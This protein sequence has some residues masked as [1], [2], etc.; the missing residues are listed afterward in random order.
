MRAV[1]ITK[2]GAPSRRGRLLSAVSMAALCT[3]LQKPAFA[4]DASDAGT[5]AVT[6]TSTRVQREGYSAPTPVTAVST[7]DLEQQ[8]PSTVGDVL[9][10]LPSFRATSTPTT[11]G[12]NSL[13]GGQVTADLRGLGASRTLV[14]VNGKRFVPAASD[15]TSDLTQIPTLLVDRVEVVT[16]GA[17]AAYG[18]DAVSGVVNFILNNHLEGLKA[19]LQYTESKYSDDIEEQAALAYGATALSGKLHFMF[20]AD[21][22]NNEGIGGQYTRPWGRQEVG[23]I[24][25]SNF[26]INKQPQ[27]IISPNVHT[28]TMSNGGLIV[29]AKTAAG[30]TSTALNGIAFGPGGTPYKFNFGTVYGSSMIG[31]EQAEPNPTLNSNL[32]KPF[33][34]ITGLSRIEYEITP[35]VTAY[36]EVSAAR[37]GAGGASQQARDTGLVIKG[38]NAFLPASIKSAM[39]ANNLSSITLGRYYDDT[40]LI[41]L[42]TTNQTYRV[43][44]GL[45]GDVNLFGDWKWDANYQYGK[46]TYFLNFGP[47]NRNQA[48]FLL[49]SDAV[50]GPGGAI[51]CRST[52][53][54]PGNG[55]IPVDVFGDGSETTNSF[56]NGSATYH[57]VTEQTVADIDVNGEP[58]S[59]WAGPV[60]VAGGLEYRREAARAIADGVSTQVN[61]DGSTGGWALG[62]QKNYAGAYNVYDGYLETVVPLVGDTPVVPLVRNID[63]NA[64]VRLTSY[65]TAGGVTTWK[66]GL[67][68]QP[69]DDLRIRGTRSHDVRAPNLSELFQGGTGS[70]YTA[71]FDKV[72]NQSTQIRQVGQGNLDLKPEKAETW[73]GGFVYQPSWLQ[74]FALS[75]DYYNIR[76]AG[77]ISSIGAPT[78]AS[79]CYSG[80]ALYC[81]SVVFN[82][83]GTINYIV[84][85]SLNL[86]TLKTSGVDFESSYN[87]AADDIIEGMDGNFN[88]HGLATFVDNLTT[89]LPGNVVQNSVGQVSNFNRISGVPKWRGNIDFTYDFNP[90]SVNLRMRYVGAGH[91]GYNLVTGSGAANTIADNDVG[92]LVY[93]DLGGSYNINVGDFPVQLYG[94]INNLFDKDPPFVPS[95]AAGG[96]NES[97]TN[98]VFYDPIGRLFKIGIRVMN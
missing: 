64:A 6:V 61:A 41:K 28:S 94:T 24:T 63:V 60:S 57:L 34:A 32:G 4:Q 69:F 40:G 42:H 55:C 85:Q 23:L 12:V 8:A 15:G 1:T 80:N 83:N 14:L 47:N 25:N 89:V 19:N 26:A 62:N 52:L 10:N 66:A 76:V 96:T 16:G 79:G 86:N 71:V 9:A 49:A 87:I 88:I 78:L 98:T 13:G 92:D 7:K 39:T 72:L 82:A 90:W 84:S 37:T 53:T 20:G 50:V 74:G 22:V 97:S 54:S 38:D 93:F 46:N 65:S 48:N 35:D 29:S 44:G 58:F 18:S 33:N 27:Y 31:G 77:V 21:Y 75:V 70:S 5:E 59:T 30:A 67:N 43:M 73:T 56:V 51:V 3:I 68:W 81:Q 36:L 95:G 91:Y 11:S 45:Q 2:T 17:S